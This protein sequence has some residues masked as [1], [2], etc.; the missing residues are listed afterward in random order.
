MN[1][2][3]VV[4]RVSEGGEVARRLSDLDLTLEGLLRVVEMGENARAEETEHDPRG[5]GGWDAY[6]F[7]V[8]GLRDTYCPT[9]W[10][11]RCEEGLELIVS[12]NAAHAVVT[13]GGNAYVGIRAAH[14]QPYRSLGGATERAVNATLALDPDWFNGMGQR[15]NNIG[16]VYMLL[17]HRCGD[18][19]RSELSLAADVDG[20]HVGTWLERIILPELTLSEPAGSRE[21][22]PADEGDIDVPVRRR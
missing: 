22:P 8:R 9:G 20:G 18:V 15:R 11:Y 14:P 7:R 4:T 21:P 12:P 16:D 3:R 17:V 6:R 19:V 5:A 13:R 10:S 2:A 1:V